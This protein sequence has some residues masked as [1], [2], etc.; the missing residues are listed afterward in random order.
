MFK[1]LMTLKKS[2]Q[3]VWTQEDSDL[4]KLCIDILLINVLW[5][6]FSHTI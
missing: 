6:H 4:I 5:Q 1:N 2:S 3:G